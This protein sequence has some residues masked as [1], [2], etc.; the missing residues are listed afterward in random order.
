[1]ERIFRG[2]CA[3]LIVLGLVLPWNM[4]AAIPQIRQI[5]VIVAMPHKAPKTAPD[6]RTPESAKRLARQ[7]SRSRGWHTGREWACLVTLWQHESGWRHNALN[8]IKVAGKHAGGIPQILGLK[9]TTAPVAQI[10]RGLAYV[11]ARYGSPCKAWRFWQRHH[12][13]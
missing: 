6:G 7:V 4:S 3:V 13:Y 5:P 8:P 11:E 12:W 2:S 1:M 9:P 10:A